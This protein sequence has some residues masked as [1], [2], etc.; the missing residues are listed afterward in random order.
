MRLQ[1]AHFKDA[2][3]EMLQHALVLWCE[4]QLLTARKTADQFNLHLEA[5]RGMA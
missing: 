4:K 1:I 5:F 2:R 3:V